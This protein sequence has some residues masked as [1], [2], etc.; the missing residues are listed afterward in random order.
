MLI[1]SVLLAKA[2]IVSLCHGT[3]PFLNNLDK[4]KR[5]L[6]SLYRF[7]KPPVLVSCEIRWSNF[8][9]LCACWNV[10]FCWFA[11]ET[12][13]RQFLHTILP[14]GTY[15]P[16]QTH[17]SSFLAAYSVNLRQRTS[18]QPAYQTEKQATPS[19]HRLCQQMRLPCCQLLHAHSSQSHQTQSCRKSQ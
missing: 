19:V 1:G 3:H 15:A 10:S 8:E 9:P 13:S 12:L 7:Q 6:E 16:Q 4:T 18:H 11:C 14:S 5:S 2:S 17:I